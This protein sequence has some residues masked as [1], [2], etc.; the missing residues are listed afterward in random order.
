MTEGDVLADGGE[1]GEVVVVAE[2]AE[3]QGEEGEAD[4]SPDDGT[5]DDADSDGLNA[6]VDPIVSD[7][8]SGRQG[9]DDAVREAILSALK[10]VLKHAG[11]NVG[12]AVIR[13]IYNI[14][15]DLIH[16]EDNRVR[17]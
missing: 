7:L 14:P 1:F 13:H 6:R 17:I 9:L 5:N 4:A 12:S 2:E 8:L 10:G 3:R 16:H 15:K 11:K